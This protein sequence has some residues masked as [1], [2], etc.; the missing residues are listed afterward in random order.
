MGSDGPCEARRVGSG[1]VGCLRE[2][3]RAARPQNGNA[4]VTS[5]PTPLASQSVGWHCR[6]PH[7]NVFAFRLSPFF[8][9]PPP[10]SYAPSSCWAKAPITAAFSR[11]PLSDGNVD[12]PEAQAG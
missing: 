8:K 11:E 12:V 6:L 3:R 7:K 9:N 2:T 1:R 5:S 4:Q 10:F